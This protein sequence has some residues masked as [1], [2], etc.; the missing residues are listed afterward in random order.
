[1]VMTK[2][3]TKDQF[4]DTEAY[5]MRGNKAEIGSGEQVYIYAGQKLNFYEKQM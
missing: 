3:F 1:M 2:T 4:G 5:K